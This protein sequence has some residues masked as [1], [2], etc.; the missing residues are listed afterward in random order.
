MLAKEWDEV[1]EKELIEVTSLTSVTKTILKSEIKV[2]TLSNFNGTYYTY[3]I[4]YLHYA[5][6]LSCFS[7]V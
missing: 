7:G 1:R 4:H 6:V 3:I 5:C 2:S